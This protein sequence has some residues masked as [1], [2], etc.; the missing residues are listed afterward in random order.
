MR[1]RQYED[2]TELWTA[3]QALD[4]AGSAEL[5]FGGERTL[6][7]L[8]HGALAALLRGGGAAPAALTEAAATAQLAPMLADALGKLDL[9]RCGTMGRRVSGEE[10]ATVRAARATLAAGA[11]STRAMPLAE[12][13]QRLERAVAE[14]EVRGRNGEVTLL[15]ESDGDAFDCYDAPPR[16][17]EVGLVMH[18]AAVRLD[19]ALYAARCWLQ[20]VEGVAPTVQAQLQALLG[21]AHAAGQD[22]LIYHNVI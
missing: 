12:R 7:R 16:I 15:D 13:I 19:D 2:T 21:A 11:A 20:Q 17:D 6:L 3:A 9:G 22:V 10:R 1:H 8:P 14:L 4:A 5:T 18:A